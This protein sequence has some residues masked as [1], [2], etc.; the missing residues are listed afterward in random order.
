MSL[1]KRKIFITIIL[2]LSLVTNH[3][4]AGNYNIKK[5]NN[6]SSKYSKP[7]ITYLSLS[8]ELDNSTTYTITCNTSWQAYPSSYWLYVDENQGIGNKTITIYGDENTELTRTGVINIYSDGNLIQ[9]L[10]V[11]QNVSSINSKWEIINSGIMGPAF[12]AIAIDIDTKKMYAGTDKG[13]IYESTDMGNYWSVRGYLSDYR[14][15]S[16]NIYEGIMYAITDHGLFHS[17]DFG[18]TWEELNVTTNNDMNITKICKSG[19]NLIVATNYGIYISNDTGKNWQNVLQN[20]NQPNNMELLVKENIAIANTNKRIYKSLD[21]GITWSEINQ[22][23]ETYIGFMEMDDMFLYTSYNIGGDG[24]KRSS[25]QG[26]TWE[27]INNGLSEGALNVSSIKIKDGIIILGTEDGFYTSS[28]KGNNWVKKGDKI[29]SANDILINENKIYTTSSKGLFLSNDNLENKMLIGNGMPVDRVN[30]ITHNN[31]K[32]IIGTE[33]GAYS[34]VNKGN[35]WA[36]SNN[37]IPFSDYNKV[38]HQVLSLKKHKNKIYSGLNYY[39]SDEGGGIYISTDNANSWN[40]TDIKGVNVVSIFCTNDSI[41]AVG[42]NYD[43]RSIY[44][45]KDEGLS[46][47]SINNGIPD[48]FSFFGIYKLGNYLFTGT[49]NGIF[50]STNNGNTWI[51]TNNGL[52]YKSYK[53][54]EVY[55]FASI[56]NNIFAGTN[57]GLYFTSDF[58]NNWTEVKNGLPEYDPNDYPRPT[59]NTIYVDNNKIYVGYESHGVYCSKDN[60]DSW[61]ALDNGLLKGVKAIDIIE[62]YIYVGTSSGYLWRG[63]QS[64]SAKFLN[65]S[66]DNLTLQYQENSK[67]T[68]EINSNTNWTLSSSETWLTMDKFVGSNNSIVTITSEENTLDNPRSAIITASAEGLQS[69]T[70]TVTQNGQEEFITVTPQSITISGANNSSGSFEIKSNTTWAITGDLSWIALNKTNGANNSTINIS[71]SENSNTN[72]RSTTLLIKSPTNIQTQITITQNTIFSNLTVNPKSLKLG[73]AESSSA[74]FDIASNGDWTIFSSQSWLKLDKTSGTGNSSITVTASA[75][76]NT[77]SRNAIVTVRG[78]NGAVEYVNITQEP[79]SPTLSVSSNEVLIGATNG[80]MASF[81]IY[82]NTNWSIESNSNWITTDKT[83]GFGYA[84]IG[85]TVSQNPFGNSRTGQL[86]IKCDGL[87]NLVVTVNQY[88]AFINASPLQITLSASQNNSSY[89]NIA[90]NVNWVIEKNQDWITIDRLQGYG[91]GR[92]NIQATENTSTAK[93]TASITVKCSDTYYKTINITQNGAASNLTVYPSN[94][95]FGYNESISSIY[96]ESNTHWKIQSDRTWLTISPMEGNGNSSVVITASQNT[97][98]N[99]RTATITIIGEGINSN[100]IIYVTQNALPHLIASPQSLT[101]NSSEGSNGNLL[102]SSNLNWTASV[103]QNWLTLSKSSGF[104]SSSIILTAS[105]NNEKSDRIAT[106]TFSATGIDSKTVTVT[107]NALSTNVTNDK[108]EIVKIYPNP[109]NDKINVS[110]PE[111]GL[112]RAAMSIYSS[113]GILVYTQKLTEQNTEISLTDLKPGIYVAKIT[114]GDKIYSKVL[115]KI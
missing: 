35:N 45:S 23:N 16:I 101:L 60:G 57:K 49:D 92:I 67:T 22:G 70:I 85:I 4:L 64:E 102:V 93:R 21:N 115:I 91:S 113:L 3:S 7:P 98:Y 54:P 87:N 9:I 14:I 56:G 105:A 28:N 42:E 73:S 100:K 8:G 65:L 77:S 32:I 66:T 97:S 37:G 38:L 50:M 20:N 86:I 51:K 1:M 75:N 63:L 11:T 81:K 40:S 25:D 103:D 94:L 29:E 78:N 44:F 106:V 48:Y 110:V 108:G 27:T 5:L 2:A 96:L 41:Y 79:A 58:G 88:M 47:T 34:S 30:A 76:T 53:Y 59:I 12:G 95:N 31:E 83:A 104:G 114:Y 15:H 62:P 39:A 68:F 82:S 69:K 112:N 43:S 6:G 46:W 19:V 24:L 107:Q 71:A 61:E 36:E 13:K 18:I 55:S 74:I 52:P 109:F 33:E 111:L 84:P 17:I 99:S 10:E 80:S 72:P 89:F 26:K 90:S